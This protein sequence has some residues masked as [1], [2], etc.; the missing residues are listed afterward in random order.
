M[1]C[2]RPLCVLIAAAIFGAGCKSMLAPAKSTFDYD[3]IYGTVDPPSDRNYMRW[4]STKRAYVDS[5]G[6]TA[7]R[8]PEQYYSGGYNDP[9]YVR[10]NY[11]HH[12]FYSYSPYH[13]W[14]W[15]P[16]N[17]NATTNDHGQRTYTPRRVIT[18]N[19]ARHSAT[20]TSSHS[21]SSHPVSISHASRGPRTQPAVG[22]SHSV[23]GGFGTLGSSHTVAHS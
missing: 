1:F 22:G 3:P 12:P 13:H 9:L 21:S 14:F 17:T 23:R 11:F 4:D 6:Q 16:N 20:T 7:Y 2:S 5:N 18:G 8:M 10:Y 15:N 19:N